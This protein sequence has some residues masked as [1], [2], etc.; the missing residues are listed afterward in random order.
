[1]TKKENHGK[2]RIT[3]YSVYIVYILVFQLYMNSNNKYGGI[4]NEELLQPLF[5]F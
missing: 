4:T 3:K 1:M 2:C 5:V